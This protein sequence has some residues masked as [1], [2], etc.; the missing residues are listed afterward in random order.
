MLQLGWRQGVK[1]LCQKPDSSPGVCTGRGL[2]ACYYPFIQIAQLISF[3]MGRIN[4]FRLEHQAGLIEMNPFPPPNR[5]FL[6]CCCCLGRGAAAFPPPPSWCAAA[7][8]AMPC[9]PHSIWEG[10]VVSPSLHPTPNPLLPSWDGECESQVVSAHCSI[11]G[12]VA[13]HT[14]GITAML[15]P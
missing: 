8:T 12:S 1:N 7:A 9:H 11:P 3:Q 2:L 13:W 15:S 10:A 14:G 4:W 5:H 6:S